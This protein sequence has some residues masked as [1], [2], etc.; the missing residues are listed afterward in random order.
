MYQDKACFFEAKLTSVEG[1]GLSVGAV[2]FLIKRR[3]HEI[4]KYVRRLDDG[5]QNFG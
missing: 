2:F 1:E 5:H 3:P 4:A